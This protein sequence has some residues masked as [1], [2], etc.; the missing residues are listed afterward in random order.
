[1]KTPQVLYRLALLAGIGILACFLVFATE[2]SSVR[3]WKQQ[4]PVETIPLVRSQEKKCGCCKKS[5][6]RIRK[7][8][9]QAGERKRALQKKETAA[10]SVDSASVKGGKEY[11][12]FVN[13]R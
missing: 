6:D 10:P 2:S 13:L 3:I 11:Q 4:P 7:R 1:M 9:Q 5:M 12:N 8:I